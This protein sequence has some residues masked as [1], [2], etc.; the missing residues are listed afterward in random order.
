[1]TAPEIHRIGGELIQQASGSRLKDIPSALS[2]EAYYAA[3]TPHA[4][5]IRQ[6]QQEVAG[7]SDPR[8][9]PLHL[10]HPSLS[11]G[12]G[13][14]KHMFHLPGT[15]GLGVKLFKEKDPIIRAKQVETETTSL[16]RLKPFGDFEQLVA[17]SPEDGAIIVEEIDGIP[18]EEAT[19]E[20]INGLTKD[21]LTRAVASIKTASDGGIWLDRKWGNILIGKEQTGLF[22][23]DP[24]P[25]IRFNYFDLN[26]QTIALSLAYAGERD[27][28]AK[29]MVSPSTRLEA[30]KRLREI[31]Q[32]QFP[33][34]RDMDRELQ[35]I[36]D[37]FE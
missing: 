31:T 1:M 7:L 16:A 32:S 22:F 12:V 17:S 10:G 8:V 30:L 9:H 2:P 4:A 23:L 27:D 6:L 29:N 35:F 13:T 33:E 14:F 34:L 11:H 25:D 15:D 28:S 3:Y 37:R 36:I 24:Y 18:L 19:D 26:I 5:V 20:M 21:I